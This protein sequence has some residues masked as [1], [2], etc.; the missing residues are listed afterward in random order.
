MTAPT[1]SMNKIIH[2]AVR[3]DLARLKAALAAFT[4]GDTARAA[5]LHKG[6]V[7]FDE[8]LTRHHEGEHRIAWPA[9]IQV[10][11]DQATLDQWDDE[12]EALAAALADGRTAMAALAA[13][14]SRADADTA[15][16]A[17]DRVEQV[18]GT[19]LANEEAVSEPVYAEHHDHPAIKE[20]G[21]KF[22]RDQPL[23]TGAEFFA[24]VTNGASPEEMAALKR[25]VPGP[26]LAI[27]PRLLGRRYY[28]EIAPIWATSGSF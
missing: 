17:V 9:L 6:W 24:W 13:S 5:Q 26:V 1:M 22:S 8:E 18:A 10:G 25:D 7:F 14:G 21:K 4:D 11:V 16:A 3:R 28:K 20:M 15:A 27:V 23:R 19:H 2:G 12:H